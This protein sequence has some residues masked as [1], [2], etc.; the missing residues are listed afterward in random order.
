MRKPLRANALAQVPYCLGVAVKISETHVTS[1]VDWG[2]RRG[3]AIVGKRG[4]LLIGALH[5]HWPNP[6]QGSGSGC[7]DRGHFMLCFLLG[8]AAASSV[9]FPLGAKRRAWI[10]LLGWWL[11]LVP[12]AVLVFYGLSHS[13]TQSFATRVTA[14]GKA[15]DHFERKRGRDTSYGFRFV[16]EGGAPIIIETEVILPSWNTPAIFDGQ[17]FRI[18][19]LNDSER[20]LKN[21][22]IDIAILSGRHAGFHDSLDARPAGAW[23]AIPIGAALAMFGFFGLR[24]MDKDAKAA[25]EDG[26]ATSA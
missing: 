10:P 22:A 2:K 20:F 1:I 13:T 4:L 18:V 3:V 17:V 26:D 5:Y 11:F 16:P 21:E 9:F 23:L 15:Y 25:A 7:M 8:A 12:G 6:N 19:Y 24:Y 14:V